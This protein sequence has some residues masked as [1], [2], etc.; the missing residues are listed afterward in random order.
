[1][2]IQLRVVVTKSLPQQNMNL[3]PHKQ[4]PVLPNAQQATVC[5][6][7]RL[8]RR[9]LAM[10]VVLR[11]LRFAQVSLLLCGMAVARATG[12]CVIVAMPPCQLS[13]LVAMLRKLLTVTVEIVNLISDVSNGYCTN[14]MKLRPRMVATLTQE[15][16]TIPL[17]PQ[18]VNSLQDPTAAANSIHTRAG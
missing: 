7:L 10:F 11:G 1:M 15:L 3:P 6:L 17:R 13:H 18:T 4:C 2:E 16:P 8:H 9:A 5:S 12:K 14:K